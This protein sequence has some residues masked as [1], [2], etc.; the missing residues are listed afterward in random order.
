M[1][2]DYQLLK[3]HFSPYFTNSKF[4]FTLNHYRED[5]QTLR[6][7]FK[8]GSL[9]EYYNLPVVEFESFKNSPSLGSYL[10][11]QIKNRYPYNRI[12]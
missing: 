1:F 10:N 11:H 12:G 5:I 7:Q 4:L 3:T 8:N 9:Y 6:V 2:A